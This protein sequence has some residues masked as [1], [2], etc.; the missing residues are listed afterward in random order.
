MKS[1]SKQAWTFYIS[2]LFYFTYVLLLLGLPE[3]DEQPFALIL[4]SYIL[5]QLSFY[6]AIMYIMIV[7]TRVFN[8]TTAGIERNTHISSETPAPTLTYETYF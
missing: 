5:D 6:P 8:E 4:T 2:S 7:H 3:L 1:I